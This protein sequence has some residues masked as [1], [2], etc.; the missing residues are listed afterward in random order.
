MKYRLIKIILAFP[1][2]P[3]NPPNTVT[4]DVVQ[5]VDKH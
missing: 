3:Y 5:N 2:L 4:S 1:A